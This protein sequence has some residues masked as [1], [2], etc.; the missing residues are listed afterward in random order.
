[1]ESGKKS[2]SQRLLQLSGDDKRI[3]CKAA[4]KMA[5]EM[6]VGYGEVGDCCNELKIKIVACEL[7]CF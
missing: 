5:E 3:S 4:R 1:M 6:G 2:I 7:G